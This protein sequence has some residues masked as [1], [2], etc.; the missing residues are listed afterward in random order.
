MGA[1][2]CAA[3]AFVALGT[4]HPHWSKT[5]SQVRPITIPLTRMLNSL[6]EHV[7][8][9]LEGT[10]NIALL[11]AGIATVVYP[12]LVL[13]FE[14]RKTGGTRPLTAIG[15][16]PEPPRSPETVPAAVTTPTVPESPPPTVT[17]PICPPPAAGGVTPP[18]DL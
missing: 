8:S 6:P 10:G 18:A 9:R 1:G 3:F 16:P 14:L 12:D 13:E 4:R 2:L 11:T 5:E 17:T 7:V 15:S